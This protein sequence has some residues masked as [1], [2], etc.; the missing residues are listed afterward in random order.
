[1]YAISIPFESSAG[2]DA[3]SLD[4]HAQC[5]VSTAGD[6]RVNPKDDPASFEGTTGV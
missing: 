5:G 1:M 6:I 4:A 2:Y 3:A